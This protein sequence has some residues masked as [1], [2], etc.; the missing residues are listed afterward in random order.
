MVRRRVA[1][2]ISGSGSNLQA[3]IDAGTRSDSAAEIVLVV[4]NRADAFGLVRAERAGIPAVVVDHRHHPDRAAFEAAIMAEL[5]AAEVE[6]VCLAGFM[7]IL[8][9]GFVEAWR[10]RMLNIHPSLLPAFRGLHT[11]A[12]ALAAGVLVHGCTVH[13]VRPE[14]DDGPILVQGIVPVLPEDDEA[15]LA[16]RVLELEH[17]CYPLALQLLASG[18][19]RVAGERV[20]AAA[21]RLLRHPLLKQSME[22]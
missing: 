15:R 17:R 10:D 9:P 13:L 3:L 6:I 16:A 19:V 8:T 1:V 11:H 20:E 4:S 7:R 18:A 12:R 21:P 14:L 2:L 5:H 22:G